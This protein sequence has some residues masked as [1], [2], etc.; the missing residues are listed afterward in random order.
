MIDDIKR[1]RRFNSSE[2]ITLFLVADGCCEECG[3]EL[4]PGW[5]ADHVTPFSRDGQTDV[6]NGQAL[7]P[8]CNQK[9]GINVG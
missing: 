5:H 3:S 7:C 9:K 4:E 8:T 1:R 6:I 2:R